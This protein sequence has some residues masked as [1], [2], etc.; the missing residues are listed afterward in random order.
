MRVI[1]PAPRDLWQAVLSSDPNALVFQSPQ[2]ID[3]V[4]AHGG[5]EDASRLYEL[6]RGRH[7]VLPLARRRNR[8]TLLRT[9]ASLPSSWAPGG[10]VA[11]G[12]VREEDVAT[13]LSDLAGRHLLRTSLRPGPLDAR[14]WAAVRPRGAVTVSRLAHVLELEGGFESIVKHR[15]KGTARTAVRKAERSGLSVERDTAGRLVP[16]VYELFERSISRWAQM[17]HEPLALARWRHRRLETL[18]KLELIA[19]TFRDA[20]HIWVAWSDHRPAA[21]IVVL[22]GDNTSFV[23][24]AM[25][26]DLAG[27]TRANYLLHRFAIEEACESGCRYYDMGESGSSRSLAQFKTRFGALPYPYAEYHLERLPITALE[28]NVRGCVKRLIGFRD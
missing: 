17:Q 27:P 6:P 24:G 23:R 26:K 12:G 11:S 4:C 16:V 7:L 13:V 18:R 28:R 8:P 25:D 14:T 22:Q 5:Y 20:C 9:E 21:A 10:I 1:T 15:F 19:A 3:S 2:W